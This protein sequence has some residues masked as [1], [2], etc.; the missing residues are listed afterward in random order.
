M[1]ASKRLNDHVIAT[2][3][4]VIASAAKQSID[5][6]GLRPRDDRATSLRA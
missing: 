6:H 1:N 4:P 3:Y 5:R 2:L